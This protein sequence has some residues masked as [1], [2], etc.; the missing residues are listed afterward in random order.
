MCNQENVQM[1]DQKKCTIKKMYKCVIDKIC[2][3]ENVQMYNQKNKISRIRVVEEKLQMCNQKNVQSRKCATGKCTIRKMG[4]SEGVQ[5]RKCIRMF[6]WK[7]N[8]QSGI[9]VQLRKF[10][11]TKSCNREPEKVGK[12]P[13]ILIVE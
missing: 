10:E 9:Y 6:N 3:Q 4:N 12:L 1:C 5:S 11:I 2:N 7:A 8:V 13:V